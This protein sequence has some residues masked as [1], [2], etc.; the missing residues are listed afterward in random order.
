MWTVELRAVPVALSILGLLAGAHPLGADGLATGAGPGERAAP[1]AT[2]DTLPPEPFVPPDHWSRDALRRLVG[3]G[4]LGTADV[5]TAWPLPR[6]RVRRHL[7]QALERTG[8]EADRPP[9]ALRGLAAALVRR[10]EA[11]YPAPDAA[12]ALHAAGRVDGGWHG[13]DGQLRGGTHE[14]SDEGGWIYTGPVPAPARASASAAAEGEVTT[15][16]GVGVRGDLRSG[17][18]GLRTREAYGFLRTT[19][20]AFW[21]GRRHLALGPSTGR[22]LVLS[23]Q[24]AFD[25]GG[26]HLVEGVRLPGFLRHLGP[27]RGST[28]L[29]RLERSGQMQRP[30]FWAARLSVAPRHDLVVGLN[31]AAIFGGEGNEPVNLRNVGLM[32]LGFTSTR[33]KSSDFEN[34]VASADVMWQT[35]VRSLPLLIH[36]EWGFSDV[37]G[38]WFRVP[39]I[40]VGLQVPAV[41][42]LPQLALGTE[43]ASFSRSGG[44]HPPWYRH[45]PLGEGWT[46]RGRILGHPLGGHG[47]EWSASLQVD[48]LSLPASGTLRVFH[49]RRGEENLLV[50]DGPETSSGAVVRMRIHGPNRFLL[51]A[52]GGWE[53]GSPEGGGDSWRAWTL[54][55]SAG[56]GF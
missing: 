11:E 18:D 20:T 26:F 13:A 51:H 53:S 7:L 8:G 2:P 15:R 34:Q 12:G 17:P 5:G 40:V 14:R 24:V 32:L 16:G 25:G 30:W 36:G 22:G 50:R 55:V 27:V 45:G 41:G 42:R 47:R 33:W 43:Y 49:R 35:R 28:V 3:A 19:S 44:G 48:P 9:P 21:L 1:M 46:D 4:I 29:A 52:D 54:R 6:D 10:F 37:G 31:R 39:G 38:A 56:L 23:G